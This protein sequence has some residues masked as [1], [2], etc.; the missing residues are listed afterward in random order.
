MQLSKCQVIN[1]CSGIVTVNTG[2]DIVD[3]F[4]RKLW[5]NAVNDIRRHATFTHALGLADPAG[6]EDGLYFYRRITEQAGKYLK[7]GGWLMYEIGCEQGADVS[8]IMQG[9]GFTEVTVKK[10]LAGLD[11][12]VIG[13]KQMQEEQHV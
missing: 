3:F 1:L 7:P 4:L 13:K 5:V 6:R 12:V 8:A 2:T 10:D 9:E 11:R